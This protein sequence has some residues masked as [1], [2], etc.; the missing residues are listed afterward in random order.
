MEKMI[1][2]LSQALSQV[3]SATSTPCKASFLPAF[4]SHTAA[5]MVGW[6]R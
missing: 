3:V 5:H 6:R 4:T 2:P 1:M